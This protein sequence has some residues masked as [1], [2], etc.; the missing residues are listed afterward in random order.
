VRKPRTHVLLMWPQM[1][2]VKARCDATELRMPTRG[3]ACVAVHGQ[4]ADQAQDNCAK[5]KKNALPQITDSVREA[6]EGGGR[7]G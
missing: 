1:L 7:A 2:S 3:W 4:C 6:T 5:R